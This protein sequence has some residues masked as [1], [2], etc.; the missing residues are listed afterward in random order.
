MDS[1]CDEIS[2]SDSESEH[3]EDS[4]VIGDDSNVNKTQNDIWSKQHPWYSG[5]V[6]HP[7]I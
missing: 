7:V 6:V 5:V 2:S 4:V 1:D 3:D